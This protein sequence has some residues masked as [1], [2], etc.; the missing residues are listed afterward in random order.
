MDVIR[1]Y[2]N[3]HNTEALVEHFTTHSENKDDNEV[4]NVSWAPENQT[5]GVVVEHAQ[6]RSGRIDYESVTLHLNENGEL[7]RGVLS[8]TVSPEQM[9]FFAKNTFLIP[10]NVPEW[11]KKEAMAGN[12]EEITWRADDKRYTVAIWPFGRMSLKKSYLY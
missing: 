12:Y 8:P 1:D 9:Q 5:I 11:T 10:E 6:D 7:A 2:V 3:A 4:K